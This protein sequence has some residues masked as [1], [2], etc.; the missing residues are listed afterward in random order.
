MNDETMK[1]AVAGSGGQWMSCI[2][3]A[4]HVGATAGL[5]RAL[6]RWRLPVGIPRFVPRLVLGSEVADHLLYFSQMARAA[7]LE[8]SGV[9]TT[10]P[11]LATALRA[12]L[13]SGS[14]T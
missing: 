10:S 6:H 2:T 11:D 3:L 9:Q 5:A 7:A 14:Y 1:G 4:D 8:Q 13:E 12:A